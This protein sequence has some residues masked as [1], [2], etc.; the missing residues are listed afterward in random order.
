MRQTF[1]ISKLLHFFLGKIPGSLCDTITGVGLAEPEDLVLK[2][3]PN[4]TG[5]EFTISFP[6]QQGSG[7]LQ[8]FDVVGNMV[9]EELVSP[10]SQYKQIEITGLP[11]GIYFCKIKWD[12]VEG[13]VKVVKVTK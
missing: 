8:L 6:A 3:F 4:P 10:W 2:L 9:K 11:D 7:L 1:S 12:E 5:G 13:R